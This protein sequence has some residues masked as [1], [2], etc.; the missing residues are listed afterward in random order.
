MHRVGALRLCLVCV[1]SFCL[2]VLANC[3]K[4]SRP[5]LPPLPPPDSDEAVFIDNPVPFCWQRSLQPQK[6]RAQLLVDSSGSMTGFQQAIPHLVNWMQHSLSRLQESTLIFEGSRSCQFSQKFSGAGG[7]GNCASITQPF[8]SYQPS[9]NTNIHDAIRSSGNYDLTFILTDG[10]AATGTRGSADCAGGVDASCIARRLREAMQ[11]QQSGSGTDRGLWLI[12]VLA[13]YDGTFYT[14]EPIDPNSFNS[15]E[16]IQ[17]IRSDVGVDAVVQAPHTSSDGRLIFNYRGPRALL[18]IIIARQTPIGRSAISALWDS[19]HL[20]GIRR[21]EQ[22]KD[23]S[24]SLA[25][26]S[27][28]EIYPGFLNTVSWKELEEVETRGTIGASAHSEGNQYSIGLDCYKDATSQG[29]YTLKGVTPVEGQVAGCVPIR[30]LPAFSFR[31]RAVRDEDE[32]E[33]KKLITGVRQE[34]GSYAKLRVRFA[35]DDTAKRY[36]GENPIAA[37]WI[38]Y[39]NYAKAADCLASPDC[40]SPGQQLIKNLSTITPSKEPHRIFALEATLRAF[41]QEVSKDQKNIPLANLEI[42]RTKLQ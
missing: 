12:P 21:V 15:Q 28:F 39:M 18:L 19:A 6:G 27:P 4:S 35:C 34:E 31:F 5:S 1:V 42:C 16:T 14:E 37:R 3:N 10:V 17:H 30:L 29:D 36:C 25:I 26:F 7:I 41:Y 13:V 24:T 40:A 22:F 11:A 38:A 33:L 32:Q 23:F 9:G 2:M 8:S 20:L